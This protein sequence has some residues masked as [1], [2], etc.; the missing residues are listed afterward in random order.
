MFVN[1]FKKMSKEYIEIIK[2]LEQEN[3]KL[4]DDIQHLK[5]LSKEQYNLASLNYSEIF[6]KVPIGIMIF[7]KDF[8]FVFI[9]RLIHQKAVDILLKAFSV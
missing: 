8:T 3:K 7:K 4:L 2:N 1:Q 5:K 6:D 9:G